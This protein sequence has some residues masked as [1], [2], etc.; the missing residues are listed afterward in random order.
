MKK[1]EVKE[2]GMK[3][4]KI[5]FDIYRKLNGMNLTKLNL[6]YCDNSK[7]YLSYPVLLD[8]DIYA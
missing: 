5:E 2:E 7:I 8:E 1:V 3:I 6:S 4:P